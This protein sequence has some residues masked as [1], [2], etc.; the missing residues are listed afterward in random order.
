MRGLTKPL[1]LA[2]ILKSVL[3]TTA[4]AIA[5]ACQPGA[6]SAQTQVA[7][8]GAD[9][10]TRAMWSGTDGSISL[11]KLDAAPNYVGSHIYGPSAGWSPV[12]LTMLGDNTY[13]LWRYTDGTPQIW[14]LDA[15]LN[16]ITART[17][18]PIGG[19]APEGLGVDP[20]GNIR[21]VWKTP[22]NQVAVW[23]IN[24]ALN[25]T[26]SFETNTA[27][28]AAHSGDADTSQLPQQEG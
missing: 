13:L 24:A 23:V 14:V 7:T 26:G 9:G 25:I 18:G 1:G 21:L 8:V 19:W 4:I 3:A 28:L 5:L 2:R 22:A 10:Y 11:W 20:Y 16:F 15:N 12:A 27:H 6:A 17:F